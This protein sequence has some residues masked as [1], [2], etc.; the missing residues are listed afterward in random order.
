MRWQLLKMRLLVLQTLCNAALVFWLTLKLC[1]IVVSFMRRDFVSIPAAP[2]SRYYSIILLFN[3]CGWA[4]ASPKTDKKRVRREAR[5]TLCCR[6]PSCVVASV[7]CGAEELGGGG[8]GG[9]PKWTV[10]V[11]RPVP[12]NLSGVSCKSLKTSTIYI[13]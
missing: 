2:Q 5:V 4:K 7:V 6:F 10:L 8:G 9:L 1:F 3:V 12:A 11:S 13:L